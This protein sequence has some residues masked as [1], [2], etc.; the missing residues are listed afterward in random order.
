MADV[1]IGVVGATGAVGTVT[2]ELLAER[3]LGDVRAFASSRSAGRTVRFGERDGGRVGAAAA[4]RGHVVFGRDALEAG[5][6]DDPL[7][8][9]LLVDAVR[10]H[11]DDLRL[12]VDGVRDD[13][14]LRAGQRDGVLAEI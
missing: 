3:S 6:E 11:L 13:P 1:R 12:A 7:A 2:L 9:Q 4:E 5:D 14:G 10:L 8:V